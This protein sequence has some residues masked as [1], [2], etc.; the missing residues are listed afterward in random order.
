MPFQM[1]AAAIQAAANHLELM[2]SSHVQGANG[3]VCFLVCL[4]CLYP[5]GLQAKTKI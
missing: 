4:C 3:K 5:Y 1:D 2:Q